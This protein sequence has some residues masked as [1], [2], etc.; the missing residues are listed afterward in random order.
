MLLAKPCQSAARRCRRQDRGRGEDLSAIRLADS[1]RWPA[2]SPAPTPRCLSQLNKTCAKLRLAF[3]DYLGAR[4]AV[5][6]LLSIVRHR[7]ASG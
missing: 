1:Y 2:R 7:C 6:Y 3:W 5:Q 4:L